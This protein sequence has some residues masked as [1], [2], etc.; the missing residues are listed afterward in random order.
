MN[1]AIYIDRTCSN[2]PCQRRPSPN[3]AYGGLC[4]YCRAS[5]SA[6]KAKRRSPAK[7]KR[8][9]EKAAQAQRDRKVQITLPQMPEEWA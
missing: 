8:L 3:P 1:H 5:Q 2:G 9:G 7:Q 6:Q 4:S